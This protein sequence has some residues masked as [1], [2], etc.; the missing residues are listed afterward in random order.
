MPSSDWLPFEMRSRKVGVELM[1][2]TT[3][4]WL[5]FVVVVFAVVKELF[6][7]VVV[8]NCRMLSL[9]KRYY[10]FYLF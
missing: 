3:G 10:P 2:A 9:M 6:V 1:N 7:V 8:A 4:W 5:N